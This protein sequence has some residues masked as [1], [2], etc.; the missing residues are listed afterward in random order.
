MENIKLENHRNWIIA[1]DTGKV[2]AKEGHEN[3]PTITAERIAPYRF[4][5]NGLALR[6]VGSDV[7]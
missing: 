4:F 3:V 6:W 1:Q 2:L 5:L 7:R